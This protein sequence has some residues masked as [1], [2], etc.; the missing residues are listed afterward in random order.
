MLLILVNSM[1][2]WFELIFPLKT[3]LVSI[4]HAQASGHLCV[5]KLNA[6][7]NISKL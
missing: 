2:F 4:Q 6:Q 5:V 7:K 3:V 1:L